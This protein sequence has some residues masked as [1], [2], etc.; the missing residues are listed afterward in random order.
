MPQQK[1]AIALPLEEKLLD[2]LH[3]WGEQF[4]WSEIHQVDFIHVVKKSV[5]PLEFGLVEMPD[6]RT[7]REMIPTL[8]QHM[9]DE[10]KKILPKDFKGDIGF[11][12]KKEF[13]PEDEV[14]STIKS[15][16]SDLLVVSTRG[17]HGFQGLFQS[18]FADKMLK[19]SPC[20]VYV[21]RPRKHNIIEGA[22]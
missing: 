16:Q 20:D 11:H 3:A 15:L 12:L 9:K 17:K 8:E 21:V 10:S 2:A 19:F 6:E 18:S 1:I 22:A 4:D 13:S 7:Y 5:T 14:I